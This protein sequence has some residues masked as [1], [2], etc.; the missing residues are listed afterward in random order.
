M[1]RRTETSPLYGLMAEFTTAR[2]LVDAARKA[3]AAGFRK[4]DGYSPFPIEELAEAIGHHHSP[5]PRIVL[6]GGILGCLGGYTLQYWVSTIAYPLNVG[7][8][9]LHSWPSFIPVTFESTVLLASFAAVL[10]ML[11]LNG[12]PTPYHPVFNVDRFALASKDRY[13]LCIESRDPL[14]EL[15][16]TRAFLQSLSPVEVHDV[17]R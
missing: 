10:G 3:H 2:A 7:G 5:L 14:F 9:P 8:R 1:G 6:G 12:L 16:K 17:D 13:F 4:M 11:A 15:E